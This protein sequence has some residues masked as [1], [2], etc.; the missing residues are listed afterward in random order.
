MHYTALPCKIFY[1]TVIATLQI[2]L[3]GY[4]ALLLLWG[5]MC[6][7]FFLA[8]AASGAI[9]KAPTT[10][11]GSYTSDFTRADPEGVRLMDTLGL[12]FRFSGES[13]GTGFCRLPHRRFDQNRRTCSGF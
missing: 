8:N 11:S 12:D 3:A 5:L 9:L 10:F 7:S 2:R 1:S 6:K 13:H 4:L